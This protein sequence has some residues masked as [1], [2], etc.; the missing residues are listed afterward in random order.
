MSKKKSGG[1]EPSKRPSQRPADASPEPLSPDLT[2]AEI[3]EQT[4][5]PKPRKPRKRVEVAPPPRAVSPDNL[6]GRF[7]QVVGSAQ[8]D[9]VDLGQRMCPTRGI[10]GS[11]H[12][13]RAAASPPEPA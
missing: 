5:G 10:R 6:T 4:S 2:T 12:D 13:Q 11:L 1:Q 9:E 8:V 3:L 7:G